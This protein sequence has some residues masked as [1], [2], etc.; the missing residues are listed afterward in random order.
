MND[1]I[2]KRRAAEVAALEEDTEDG[3]T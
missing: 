3:D 1:A 2:S